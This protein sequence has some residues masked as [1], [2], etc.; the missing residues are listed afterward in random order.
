MYFL[1]LSTAGNIIQ[2]IPTVSLSNFG[3]FHLNTKKYWWFIEILTFHLVVRQR[4]TLRT[5]AIADS[6]DSGPTN[7]GFQTSP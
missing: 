5:P 2:L 7:K 1:I 4:K 6:C 3:S